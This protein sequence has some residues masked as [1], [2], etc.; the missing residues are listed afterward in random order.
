MTASLVALVTVFFVFPFGYIGY[1]NSKADR[2]GH[3]GS[4]SPM[5]RQAAIRGAY[6]NTGSKDVGY[7][8][9]FYKRNAEVVRQLA[10][11]QRGGG[12]IASDQNSKR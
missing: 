11:A 4:Q 1:H 7:D 12:S 3:Y 8:N 10:E 6:I 2:K 9:E 5:V